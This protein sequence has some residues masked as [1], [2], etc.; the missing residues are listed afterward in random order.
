HGWQP[1][2]HGRAWAHV[3]VFVLDTTAVQRY[4]AVVSVNVDLATV[5][6]SAPRASIHTGADAATV[7]ASPLA[8]AGAGEL[9]LKSRQ[10]DA[11]AR[12]G[13]DVDH[14]GFNRSLLLRATG[15]QSQTAGAT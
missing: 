2:C 8:P 1:L 4:V 10:R 3:A 5:H 13:R 11:R 9:V 7:E 14:G 15:R 12:G 6:V